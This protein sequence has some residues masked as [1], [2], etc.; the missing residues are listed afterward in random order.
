MTQINVYLTFDGNCAEAMNFYH[1]CLGGELTVNKVAGSPAEQHCPAA[2]A[3]MV[4]HANIIKDGLVL[5]AS[6]NLMGAELKRG[7]AYAVSLNCSS[8]EE[9]NDFFN[10]LSAGG[11]VISPL[12][13][14]FWG[15]IF[16][17]FDDKFGIHWMVNFDKNQP[18]A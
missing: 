16:G 12:K 9:I 6:D 1:Q 7:N 17:M 13:E 15:A 2:M 4:M 5:M 3:D 14:E 10:K 18:A 11:K 8:E